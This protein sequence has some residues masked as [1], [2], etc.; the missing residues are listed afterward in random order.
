LKTKFSVLF[1]VLAFF[2]LSTGWFVAFNIIRSQIYS[3]EDLPTAPDMFIQGVT[4]KQMD[5]TGQI[6]HQ[7]FTPNVTHYQQDDRYVL[8]APDLKIIDDSKKIWH[9]R[10]LNGISKQG[11]SVIELKDN[12]SISEFADAN[13]EVS[14]LDIKTTFL[15]VYPDT[16]FAE[17]AEP[18]TITQPS[19]VVESVG[20]KLDMKSGILYLLSKVKGQYAPEKK[21]GD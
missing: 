20:A 3:G 9:I 19:N 1:F 6:V 18:V 16:K 13:L 12:V 17:T 2:A 5:E 8:Q 7:L 15:T 14:E 4:F 10:A 21:V 11:Q